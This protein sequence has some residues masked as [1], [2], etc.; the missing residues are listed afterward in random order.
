MSR[1]SKGKVTYL[2]RLYRIIQFKRIFGDVTEE[3]KQAWDRWVD[4]P[5]NKGPTF[6]VKF[7]VQDLSSVL[8]EPV[9]QL[10][11]K[12]LFTEKGPTNGPVIY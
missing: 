11:M 12:T 6:P 5:K 9:D 10:P 7:Q 4:A 3:Q 2:K 8:H 1:V